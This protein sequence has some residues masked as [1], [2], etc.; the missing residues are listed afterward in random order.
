MSVL[1]AR[2]MPE[3]ARSP[4][5]MRLTATRLACARGGRIVFADLDFAVAAGQAMAVTGPNGVG[6]TTLLRLIAGLLRPAAGELTLDGGDPEASLAEQA[7]FLGHQDALKPALTVSE[8]LAFWAGYLGGA[9]SSDALGT[10]G[11]AEL[12][13]VPAG[14]L[15]AGQRRRLALGRLT[16]IPRPLWLLDEPT[17]ALD[18]AA[19]LT[20]G[21][22][23]QDHLAGGGIIVAATHAPLP[24]AAALELRL[25][26]KS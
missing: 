4:A 8:N 18:H 22:L 10:W 20:L 11:L 25:G 5:L 9:A 15:S 12:G 23:M 6:K 7:H 17:T 2:Q 16:A 21:R 26:P 24:L 3:M 1:L 19:Q 14:F 13:A